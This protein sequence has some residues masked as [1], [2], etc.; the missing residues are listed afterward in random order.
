MMPSIVSRWSW[1]P[2]A[3]RNSWTF[4]RNLTRKAA[5]SSRKLSN[6]TGPASR[7]Q[8]P[9]RRA[10][11]GSLPSRRTETGYSWR[12]IHRCRPARKTGIADC[13]PRRRT[14]RLDR[15]VGGRLQADR[16]DRSIAGRNIRRRIGRSSRD[17]KGRDRF[18]GN[19]R[20][21]LRRQTNDRPRTRRYI[22][23]QARRD[24]ERV[25]PKIVMKTP[26]RRSA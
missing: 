8:P 3:N 10:S 15:M 9:V 12:L 20:G 21:F 25:K 7:S 18:P 16:I 17:R 14:D 13:S 5:L 6:S 2:E 4:P 22:F 24:A 11:T 23:G 26:D 1:L 19:A